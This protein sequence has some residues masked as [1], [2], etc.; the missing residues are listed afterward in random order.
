MVILM[1]R[2][3]HIFIKDKI[4]NKKITI[5]NDK[6]NSYFLLLIKKLLIIKS[7]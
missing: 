2:Y 3:H 6:I 7:Y 1:K 4:N 5:N